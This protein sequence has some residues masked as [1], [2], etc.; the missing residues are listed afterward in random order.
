MSDIDYLDLGK[1]ET[2]LNKFG[3]KNRWFND[4]IDNNFLKSDSKINN[5]IEEERKKAKNL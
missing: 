1:L 2:L 3:I 4:K 5:I